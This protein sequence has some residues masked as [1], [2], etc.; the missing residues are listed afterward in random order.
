M[1][2]PNVD[3]QRAQSAEQRAE[4]LPDR[5]SGGEMGGAEAY[6]KLRGLIMQEED[7]H[8]VHGLSWVPQEGE[9]G[10][11]LYLIQTPFATWP[12]YVVGFTD[13]ENENPEILFRCGQRDNGWEEFNR[14]NCGDHK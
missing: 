14:Q 12:K 9:N 8:E 2:T 7:V 11:W 1:T 3:E 5:T 10:K 13:P 4:K 6:R